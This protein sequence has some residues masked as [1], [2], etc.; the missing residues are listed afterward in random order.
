MVV[1][2]AF[3]Q[4]VEEWRPGSG[5]W[6]GKVALTGS[7][8]YFCAF[9]PDYVSPTAYN[10]SRHVRTHTGERPFPCHLCPRRFSDNRRLKE[11]VLRAHGHG[12]SLNVKEE[13]GRS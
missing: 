3:G 9:C 4:S 12:F 1:G 13:D 8:R 6:R 11:H 2:L 5:I 10:V 7:W